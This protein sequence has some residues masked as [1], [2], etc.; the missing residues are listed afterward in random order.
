[1]LEDINHSSDQFVQTE[2]EILLSC[3]FKID[4]QKTSQQLIT[5]GKAFQKICKQ[6][7]DIDQNISEIE[8]K[9]ANK[10]QQM[11]D[12]TKSAKRIKPNKNN[13]GLTNLTK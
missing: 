13:I 8:S 11:V 4:Q 2:N 9:L 3:N 10:D 5:F 12:E 7:D 1:M 6:I